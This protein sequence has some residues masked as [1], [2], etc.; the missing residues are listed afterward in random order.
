ME[1][2]KNIIEALLFVADTP[3]TIERFK[4]TLAHSET[5][6]IRDAL[7][8][9][10]DDYEARRGGFYLREVAGGYQ[11][12]TRPEHR[13]WIKLFLQPNPKRLSKAALETLA[14][15]AYKQPIIRADIEHIRGVDCGGVLRM[16]LERK[17]IRI[18]GRKEIPGRPL[19]YA[20]TKTFLELFDLKDLRDLP[21]LKEIDAYGNPVEK[22]MVSQLENQPETNGKNT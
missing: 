6:E 19:I 14:I 3:V 9:L 21:T 1:D 17:L 11:L 22:N 7:R 10:A 16:L 5:K 2:I 20:T 18:L 4:R 15:I 12:C 8:R 13:Q